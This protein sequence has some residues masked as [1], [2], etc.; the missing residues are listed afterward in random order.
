MS[1][2]LLRRAAAL[3]RERAEARVALPK[4]ASRCVRSEHPAAA[5]GHYGYAGRHWCS[6]FRSP[7]LS[8]ANMGSR[9]VYAKPVGAPDAF[10]L[11]VAD[12]LDAVAIGGA[13]SERLHALTVARAYLGEQS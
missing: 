3:M 2:D 1:A 9:K 11:A 6:D 8:E 7:L 13:E 5:H 4:G 12:W 10:A